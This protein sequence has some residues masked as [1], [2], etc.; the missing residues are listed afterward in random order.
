[1]KK[2]EE[3]EMPVPM[4]RLGS[5]QGVPAYGIPFQRMGTSFQ[6]F[7][8]QGEEGGAGGAPVCRQAVVEVYIDLLG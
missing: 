8:V 6:V 4:A 7:G 2:W 1:M 3:E 5:Y